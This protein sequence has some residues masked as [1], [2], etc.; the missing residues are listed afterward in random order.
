L[1]DVGQVFIVVLLIG[2]GVS[3]AVWGVTRSNDMVD[4]WAADNGYRL[5]SKERRFLRRGPFLLTTS[6]GQSVHYVT[7]EDANRDQRSGYLRCGSWLGG[8]MSDKVQVHW[9]DEA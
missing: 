4:R 5:I 9:D 3:C 8:L 2:V 1:D 6:K 7:V